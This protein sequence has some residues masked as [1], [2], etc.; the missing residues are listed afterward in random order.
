MK[1]VLSYILA[2]TLLITLPA[3]ANSA[4]AETDY[5]FLNEMSI[6]ELEAL[7][8]EIDTRISKAKATMGSSDPSNMGAWQVKYYV[9]EFN[10]PTSQGYITTKDYI[11]GTFSNSAT[12]NSMLYV[13]WLIDGEDVAI[14]LAEYG[15]NVVK[16]SY[17]STDY[18]IIMLDPD[19]K[20]ISMS[21]TM[22]KGGDRIYIDSQYESTVLEALKK[23][24]SVTF[25]IT[26]DGKYASSSYLFKMEDTSY[27]DNAYK[28]L[29]EN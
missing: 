26:E 3:I 25:K 10:M 1:K 27:F 4:I 9:D 11:T 2:L 16:S 12:T 6:D 20:K 8:D 5:S 7:S 23:N 18:S 29:T 15:R 14:K 13:I 17:D 21:G 24:G 22:Y 19:G 28:A